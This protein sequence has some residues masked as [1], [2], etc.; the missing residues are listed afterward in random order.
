MKQL[1]SLLFVSIIFFGCRDFQ[2]ENMNIVNVTTEKKVI[3]P[4]LNPCTSGQFY[5]LKTG[6][7]IVLEHPEWGFKEFSIPKNNSYELSQCTQEAFEKVLNS[8]PREGGKI[9]LPA[10][11]IEIDGGVDI[12]SNIIIEGAGIGKTIIKNHGVSCVLR[13]TGENNIIR[14][15]TV[16]G[17]GSSLN[18]IDGW[19]FKGNALIE[20]IQ[21]KHFRRNQGSGIAFLTKEPIKNARITI[22]YNEAFDG[23]HGIDVKVQR[24]ANALIYSNESYNN[25]NYGIDISTNKNIEVAG[26]YLHHNKVAGA[27]SPQ[28]D[29]IIYHNNTVNYNLK[30]GLVYMESNPSAEIIVKYNDLTKNGGPAYAVWNGQLNTLY[31]FDNNVSE[32]IDANGYSIGATGVKRLIVRGNYGRVWPEGIEIKSY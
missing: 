26:N 27:K 18:G 7:C 20:H 3:I 23:L 9:K 5:Q 6:K 12:P 29:Q 21:T 11:T 13:L 24:L 1:F 15:L 4:H 8:I 17:S 14:H 19:Q 28:A 32:S 16:D 10:C 31:F 30:A 25:E 22:R 2:S